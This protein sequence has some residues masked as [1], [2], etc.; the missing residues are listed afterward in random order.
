MISHCRRFRPRALPQGR[1]RNVGKPNGELTMCGR[2][3]VG[4]N[5]I[6]R[7]RPPRSL[8]ALDRPG[9]REVEQARMA[10]P[11][12]NKMNPRSEQ[13]FRESKPQGLLHRSVRVSLSSLCGRFLFRSS[14]RVPHLFRPSLFDVGNVRGGIV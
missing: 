9:E 3:C 7:S 11:I 1:L 4:A 2:Y 10:A 12:L 13:T 6:T 5:D 8:S 14:Q